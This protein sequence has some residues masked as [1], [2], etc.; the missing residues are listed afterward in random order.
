[1]KYV[2]KLHIKIIYG[3][4]GDSFTVYGAMCT[5]NNNVIQTIEDIFFDIH[6]AIDFIELCNRVNLHPDY[7]ED[8]ARNAVEEQYRITQ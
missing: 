5:L 4:P 7:F 8:M 6:K 3:E 1:M 2:Y